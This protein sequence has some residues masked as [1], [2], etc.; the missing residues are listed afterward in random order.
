MK[1]VGEGPVPGKFTVL[2][3]GGRAKDR[4]RVVYAGKSEEEAFAAFDRESSR[5][6]QGGVDLFDPQG[7]KMRGSWAP[8]LRTKW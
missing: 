3:H 8:A 5:L 7:K 4:W 6:R 2:R 1:K